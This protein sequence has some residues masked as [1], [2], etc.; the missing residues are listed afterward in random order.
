MCV[1]RRNHFRHQ[2]QRHRELLQR[3]RE[4]QTSQCQ[5]CAAECKQK[6]LKYF[7][8]INRADIVAESGRR[9]E[10]ENIWSNFS[11]FSVS[12][13]FYPGSERD[14]LLS[15]LTASIVKISEESEGPM[16]WLQAS[17]RP[18]NRRENIF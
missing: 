15:Q 5:V 17:L 16:T 12:L 1:C 6:Q 18:F 9:G 13:C 7:L 14:G 11:L 10:S 4:H 2:R 8:R 3:I